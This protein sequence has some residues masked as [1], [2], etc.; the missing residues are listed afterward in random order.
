M[1]DD[2][3]KLGAQG[4]GK[5]QGKGKGKYQGKG[6]RQGKGKGKG[7]GKTINYYLSANWIQFL[8]RF[9]FSV[10]IFHFLLL[11]GLTVVWSIGLRCSY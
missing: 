11:I 7:K 4:K 10:L 2:N 1:I 8:G 3:L 6:K 9:I 5:H